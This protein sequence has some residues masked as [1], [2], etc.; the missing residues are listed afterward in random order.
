MQIQKK[1][2]TSNYVWKRIKTRRTKKR[3]RETENYEMMEWRM[4]PKFV[5]QNSDYQ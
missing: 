5:S 4:W 1:K 2:Q 3:E